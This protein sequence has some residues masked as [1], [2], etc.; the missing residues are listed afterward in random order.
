MIAEGDWVSG[1]SQ[2]DE[3]FIGFVQSVYSEGVMKVVVTQSDREEIVGNIIQAKLGKVKKLLEQSPSSKEELNSLIELAL[4]T[5]DKAW[6]EEL[7]ARLAD[8][9]APVAEW[10]G[11][12]G[13]KVSRN[14]RLFGIATNIGE[15]D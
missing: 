9:S 1:A 11:L 3:K 12:N 10:T 13:G 4:G 5:H 6:F 7:T 8:A 15:V 2:Q 14:S